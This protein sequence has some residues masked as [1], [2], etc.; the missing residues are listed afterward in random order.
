VQRRNQNVNQITKSLLFN[1]KNEESFNLFEHD[2]LLWCGDL[3]YRIASDSFEDVVEK[4]R[5][6]K[7]SDL[8][9]IDQLRQEKAAGNVFMEFEEA[10]L[11]FP[12]TY[13]FK[14][15]TSEY[16]L[17]P[18]KV[19]IPSWCDRILFR[20][21]NLQQMFYTSIMTPTT[22]DHKPVASLFKMQYKMIDPVQ[23]KIV[24]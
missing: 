16:D 7:L 5:A 14:V 10:K 24:T 8:R 2:I 13:K 18:S 19:R 23:Q 1:Y 20:G 22:S 9:A 21:E 6:N 15:G 12:P 11:K 3:N 4:I 17:K